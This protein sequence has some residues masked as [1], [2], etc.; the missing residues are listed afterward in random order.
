GHK[1]VTGLQRVESEDWRVEIG[2]IEIEDRR[3]RFAGGAGGSFGLSGS[4]PTGGLRFRAAGRVSFCSCRKKPK[5]RLGGAPP[6][7][8]GAKG[9][10]C[11]QS[12]PPKN[13]RFTGAQ[14]RCSILFP[15]HTC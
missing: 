14:N 11:S 9:A 10:P 13:P 2:D 5:T 12:A 7:R 4:A 8:H 1:G 6:V 3:Y 15:A